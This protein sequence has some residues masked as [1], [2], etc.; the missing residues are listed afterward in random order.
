MTPL[1]A[2]LLAATI[3]SLVSLVGILFLLIKKKILN[4]ILILLVGFSAGALIG[5]AFLHLIPEAAESGEWNYVS[6]AILIGFSISL[7]K[8]YPTN[9]PKIANTA[10]VKL[11]ISALALV[12]PAYNNTPKSEIS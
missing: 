6:L 4:K 9:A 1:L 12:K 8:K 5:G 11:N 7:D 2:S 10:E 3:I